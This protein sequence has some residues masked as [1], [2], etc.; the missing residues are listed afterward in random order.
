MMF[1]GDESLVEN[2]A[3]VEGKESGIKDISNIQSNE[4]EGRKKP[5]LTVVK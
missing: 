2:N 5:V 3:E 4:K 1:A